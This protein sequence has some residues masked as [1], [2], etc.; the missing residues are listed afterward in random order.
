[1]PRTFSMNE[2]PCS[3]SLACMDRRW[4]S[5]V[6]AALLPLVPRAETAAHWA[7]APPVAR[8]APAA[9]DP[10]WNEHEVDRW[11]RHGLESAGLTPAPEADRGTLLRRLS[12]T[13]TGLPPTPTELD[14]FLSDK[15]P[16]AWERQ[17]DRLLAAPAYGERMARLWLDL[18]RYADSNGQ[19]ENMAMSHA[20]RYRDWVVGAFNRDLPYAEFIRHQLAGDLLGGG[21]DALTATGFL[22]L[23]PKQLAEQDKEKML[24]DIADEQIDTVGRTFLGMSLGCARCHDHKSDP[25]TARDYYAL[26]GIFRS[27]RTMADTGFVS[28]WLERDATPPDV[29]RAIE[30]R[31]KELQDL[32]RGLEEARAAANQALRARLEA[33][34][35]RYLRGEEA[36]DLIPAVRER[37][38]AA[39]AANPGFAGWRNLRASSVPADD[40]R[41]DPVLSLLNAAP[42]AE[43]AELE[44]VFAEALV[45]LARA[46]APPGVPGRKGGAWAES[47]RK[48]VSVPHRPELEPDTFTLEAWVRLER[49][50]D[51]KVDDRRWIVNK[52]D[53]EWVTGH[54][55]LVVEGTKALAYLAPTGGREKQTAVRGEIALGVGE[56]V[57]LAATY[58]GADLRLYLNG[59]PDG[60]EPVPQPRT[61]G[62]GALRIG[63]RADNYNGFPE[64]AIDDVA[65]FNRAL[66]GVE[67]LHRFQS[68][69]E[70]PPAGLVQAWRFDPETPEENRRLALAALAATVHG[71]KG[72]FASPDSPE[73]HWTEAHRQ[74]VDALVLRRKQVQADTLEEI[75]VLAVEESTPMNLRLHVRGDLLHLEGEPLAR[76]VPPGISD[77]PPPSISPRSSGRRELADWLCDPRHPLTARVLVNRIWQADFGQGLVP[78][79]DNFG[80]TGEPPSHPE[81]LDA[82]ALEFLADGG[83][84]KRLHRRLLTSRAWRASV[85]RDARAEEIDPGNRLLWRANRRRLEA[86]MIRDSVLAVSG[87]LDPAMGGSLAAF[88][89]RE[90]VPK[91]PDLG[92]THRRGLY[93]PVLR[94]RMSAEFALFDFAQP[95]TCTGKRDATVVAHQ[96][97]YFLNGDLVRESAQALARLLVEG[98]GDHAAR[99]REAYLRVFARLP[100]PAETERLAAFLAHHDPSAAWTEI[101]Q[102]LLSTNEFLYL[103]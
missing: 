99:V 55:A 31:R 40:W 49:A 84:I 38:R 72:L 28:K 20:W 12:F 37:W 57:H 88:K 58:D 27:T 83:S 96:A 5:L 46:P 22:V 11:I 41:R 54:F 14:A 69:D 6:L 60:R 29:R 23:G 73:S 66:S 85:G 24:L 15:S 39:L 35:L 95:S 19:D 52:N 93:L 42:P 90:Y 59:V 67:I 30:G 62:S 61:K 75:S 47:V 50:P 48:P 7:F 86:E 2:P 34:A 65:L 81:L 78:T 53:N 76:G 97:L 79:P 32:D 80:T 51:A 89:N 8:A 91:D 71:P 92:A 10:A 45:D 70:A 82:L 36:A 74:A 63:G 17:V 100:H 102:A 9:A 64:G 16:G 87:R 101:G 94:D 33:D 18:A 25:V 26:A 13:L 1:M 77:L 21:H 44:R 4:L 68:P 103:D 98:P 56:W 3:P 43:V